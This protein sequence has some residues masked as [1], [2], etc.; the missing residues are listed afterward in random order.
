PNSGR[1][2]EEDLQLAA[3]R[4]ALV[5]TN[6]R[7]QRF[8]IRPASGH[9]IR[10]AIQDTVSAS[11]VTITKLLRV[12]FGMPCEGNTA[13]VALQPRT[14]ARHGGPGGL[15]TSPPSDA[16]LVRSPAGAPVTT[17]PWCGSL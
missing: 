17:M 14:S 16:P 11:D 4:A 6:A 1:R 9:V 2:A 5:L 10:I 13:L 8:G 3:R 15:P 7:Q 12:A